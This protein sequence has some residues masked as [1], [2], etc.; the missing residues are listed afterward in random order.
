MSKIRWEPT[1]FWS[2]EGIRPSSRTSNVT[3]IFFISLW[4][5]FLHTVLLFVL[6]ILCA[7][8][9]LL[10][11][12]TIYLLFLKLMRGLTAKMMLSRFLKMWGGHQEKYDYLVSLLASAS[13]ATPIGLDHFTSL[14]GIHDFEPSRHLTRK[15]HSCV[16]DFFGFPSSGI[17]EESIVSFHW[18]NIKSMPT[19][20]F[21]YPS[22]TPII[23]Y[24]IVRPKRNHISGI[25][26]GWSIIKNNFIDAC[27]EYCTPIVRANIFTIWLCRSLE[28][29]RTL[30]VIPCYKYNYLWI[31]I[32][33][34]IREYTRIC[35]LV[36]ILLFKYICIKVYFVRMRCLESPSFLMIASSN[37]FSLFR[38][39]SLWISIKVKWW[40]DRCGKHCRN[41]LVH[42]DSPLY[43]HDMHDPSIELSVQ[44]VKGKIS[45]GLC[46][47]LVYTSRR[48]QGNKW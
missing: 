43:L 32:P 25:L 13:S 14:S 21:K 31:Y 37:I 10:G 28:D 30:K 42:T 2:G 16:V 1:R 3:D 34:I 45:R 8:L 40:R 4:I 5:S 27:V 36:L 24:L 12:R 18:S 17:V 35:N 26:L 48:Q 38:S 19:N 22:F 20:W 9:I 11:V 6:A 47:I 46:S 15:C 41:F 39:I 33:T 29:L 7:S 23:I 44:M